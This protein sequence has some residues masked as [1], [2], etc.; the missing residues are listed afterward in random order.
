ML[1]I[2]PQ[3]CDEEEGPFTFKRISHVYITVLDA[4][5]NDLLAPRSIRSP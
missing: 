2:L 3:A 5:R 1:A 4:N